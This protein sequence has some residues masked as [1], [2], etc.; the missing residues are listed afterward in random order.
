MEG[1]RN[2]IMMVMYSIGNHVL[3]NPTVSDFVNHTYSGCDGKCFCD[4]LRTYLIITPYHI[5]K[6]FR[7]VELYARKQC[8]FIPLDHA[9]QCLILK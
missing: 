8:P 3:Y 6:I 7:Y 5:R 2:T 1:D 9:Y 4:L